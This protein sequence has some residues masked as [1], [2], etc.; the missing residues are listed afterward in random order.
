MVFNDMITFYNA[1]WRHDKLVWGHW[2]AAASQCEHLMSL[3]SV[4][5]TIAPCLTTTVTTPALVG[6][7]IIF[8]WGVKLICEYWIQPQQSD[9]LCSEFGCVRIYSTKVYYVI[10]TWRIL[11]PASILCNAVHPTIPH[12]AL[13]QTQ[14]QRQ[15][16][17]PEAKEDSEAGEGDGSPQWIVNM[18]VMMWASKRP[19][20]GEL[21]GSM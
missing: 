13:P 16:D 2:R 11:G 12:S 9:P 19:T 3:H 18:W 4:M 17:Y 8:C 21:Q 20:L 10:D 15:Q 6:K 7:V 1:L 5:L 14:V